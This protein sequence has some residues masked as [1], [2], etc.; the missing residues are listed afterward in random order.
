MTWVERRCLQTQRCDFISVRNSDVAPR[1]RVVMTVPNVTG[2]T[3]AAADVF[4]RLDRL[5]IMRPHVVWVILLTANL[6]LEYYDNGLFAYLIPSIMASVGL[7]LEQ[8]GILTSGFFVGM[9]LGALVGGRLADRFGRRWLLL[10]AT[11]VYSGGALATAFAGSFEVI[12]VARVVTGIGVQAATS[13]LLVYIAEMFPSRTRGRVVSIV[14]TAFV[15]VAPVISLLALFTIPNGGPETWRSLFVI[16]GVGLLLVP[17][18]RIFMPESARWLATRG[19]L[20]KAAEIVDKLERRAI[21]LGL[22]L[23]TPSPVPEGARKARVR[24]IFTN[25]RVLQSIVVVALG[26]FGATL[27]LYLFANWQF[28]VLIDGLSFSEEYAYQIG[29]IW[30]L[31]YIIT[32]VVALL[33]MDRIERK[34]L[35]FGLSLLTAVPLIIFGYSNSDW[36]VITAGAIAGIITGVI[37]TAFYAYIPEAVPT[38]ARG[39]GSGIIISV[40]RFGGAASGVLGAFLYAGWGQGGLMV[41]AAASYVLFA[42]VLFFL[43]PRTTRRSLEDVTADELTPRT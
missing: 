41:V 43:G 34:T 13:A 32:P 16:G 1:K 14:T 17:L 23:P 33:L 2:T 29:L 12:L 39:L 37:V 10:I 15:I 4:A 19:D 24:E 38:Q 31:V 36:V 28:Y 42:L 22:D 9:I 27:G 18:V 8:I 40:G 26:Y 25:R 6:M 3:S 20:A 7:G 30:S 11:I 35:I 5:P 21:R